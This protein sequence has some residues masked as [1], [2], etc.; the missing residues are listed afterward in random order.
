MLTIL[1]ILWFILGGFLAGLGWWLAGILCAITIVGLPWARACFM[2]GNFTFWPFGRDVIS[3]KELTGRDDLGTGTFGTIG[4]IIWLIF[5]GWWLALGHI[6][7]AISLGLT[8]I[9]IP[10]AIQHLKL[11]YASLFPIGQT[12]VDAEMVHEARRNRAAT[13]VQQL[14][15]T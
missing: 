1:N 6:M 13:Q 5:A 4:N 14:R 2:L 7:L 3:R 15:Q 10:F 12:V 8:I 11:A 9:G